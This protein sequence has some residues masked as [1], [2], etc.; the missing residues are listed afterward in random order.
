MKFH[1]LPWACLPLCLL[2]QRGHIAQY[3][4]CPGCHCT[5]VFVERSSGIS[6][7]FGR[8]H[9]HPR[10][11][12]PPL[13][14][15]RE[16][17]PSVR[18]SLCSFT[19]L[20][21]MRPY[22]AGWT[23]AILASMALPSGPGCQGSQHEI[24]LIHDAWVISQQPGVRWDA[25]TLCTPESHRTA[26]GSVPASAWGSCARSG[27]CRSGSGN[28]GRQSSYLAALVLA[29]I[30]WQ[31]SVR[32]QQKG[33]TDA[34]LLLWGRDAYLH[35]SVTPWVNTFGTSETLFQRGFECHMNHRR[36]RLGKQGILMW[37]ISS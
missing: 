5:T 26:C 9:K 16:G 4:C 28:A 24:V 1:H 3:C 23:S 34:F 33:L 12:Q 25:R 32:C 36:Y 15:T 37:S 8:S 31:R 14:S 2:G 10:I 30:E 17:L 21:D 7:L 22:P 20:T 11:T 18:F 6:E 19:E 35:V 13:F 29:G 27:W